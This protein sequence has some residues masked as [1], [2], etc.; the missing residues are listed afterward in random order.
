MQGQ[1]RLDLNLGARVSSTHRIEIDVE[2]RYCILHRVYW[3]SSIDWTDPLLAQEIPDANQV[4]PLA[5]IW[6][7]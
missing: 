2:I 6:L 3:R 7:A 4:Y 5:M 1:V